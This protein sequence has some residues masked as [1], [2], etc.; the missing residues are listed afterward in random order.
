MDAARKNITQSYI[1][2]LRF[3]HKLMACLGQ[4]LACSD[5]VKETL[6]RKP[7][8]IDTVIGIY[9]NPDFKPYVDF[10]KERIITEHQLPR[11]VMVL[12]VKPSD[13]MVMMMM[14]PGFIYALQHPEENYGSWDLEAHRTTG[15]TYH[16]AQGM[17]EGRIGYNEA[18]RMLEAIY[19]ELPSSILD[20]KYNN[21]S[22][23]YRTIIKRALK[24]LHRMN[25]IDIAENKRL[26]DILRSGM[27][28]SI[29]CLR[30]ILRQPVVSNFLQREYIDNGR[31]MLDIIN[32]GS[33][34]C[35]TKVVMM[36]SYPAFVRAIE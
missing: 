9:R 11:L 29:E 31:L 30:N 14:M 24:E 26:E 33:L 10:L 8:I 20:S 34:K 16:I 13:K 28:A 3:A 1:R 23:R 27:K 18:M 22:G 19:E 6:I 17:K 5:G 7:P 32:D 12:N 21:I 2:I 4:H 15:N 35:Y 36:R 25:I